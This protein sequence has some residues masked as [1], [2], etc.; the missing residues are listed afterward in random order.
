ML[1]IYLP[2][3]RAVLET[4]HL[5]LEPTLVS[6]PPTPDFSESLFL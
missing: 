5:G 3:Q 6:I 1:P 2:F 4:V